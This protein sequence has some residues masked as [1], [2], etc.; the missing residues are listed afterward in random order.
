MEVRPKYIADKYSHKIEID[1]APLESIFL[2]ILALFVTLFLVDNIN[3][4][5][6]PI[7]N[8]LFKIKRHHFTIV[9][10]AKLNCLKRSLS[11]VAS[12]AQSENWKLL[13]RVIFNHMFP[14][15]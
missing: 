14:C 15:S 9:Q 1:R 7:H 13:V 6:Q 11:T 2:L 4:E 5:L 10:K 8:L 12:K 3:R